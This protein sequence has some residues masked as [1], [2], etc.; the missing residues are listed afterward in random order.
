MVLHNI[1]RNEI[2]SPATMDAMN[3]SMFVKNIVINGNEKLI[4]RSINH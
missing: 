1:L 3:E 4:T 2:G